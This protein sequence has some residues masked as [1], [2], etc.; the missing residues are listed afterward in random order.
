MA[1]T[2]RTRHSR[3]KREPVTIDLEPEAVR[4]ESEE[5]SA[6]GA[7]QEDKAGPQPAGSEA[8]SDAAET[9]APNSNGAEQ[10]AENAES[11]AAEEQGAAGADASEVETAA[12]SDGD[13]PPDEDK[14][15]QS[16]ER[17]QR[18]GGLGRALAAG[19]IGGAVALGLGAG[20]QRANI[21][22][23]GGDTG[24]ESGVES[25]RQELASIQSELAQMRQAGS[26]AAPAEQLS[27][28][29]SQLAQLRDT[30]SQLQSA[31]SGGAQSGELAQRISQ[32]E[33]SV[34]SAAKAAEAAQQTSAGHTEQLQ[35]I[36]R[37]VTELGNQVESQNEGPRLALIVAASALKSAVE[38][39]SPFASE[40]ETYTAL[41]PDAS[42]V[43]P[44]KPYA[45]TGVP[46]QAELSNEVPQVASQIAALDSQVPADAG[47]LDRLV[48]S[49]RTV[50]DVRP[51]G[52]VE[53]EAPE[54][55][56][57]RMEAAVQKGDY[58]QALTEY[59]ALP[60]QAKDVASAFADKLRARQT[61][62]RIL[63]EAL[64][65]ALKPA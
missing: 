64:S 18:G 30:V 37:Q 45:E 63:K 31:P 48:A 47:L 40:L 33:T 14:P 60:P 28:L 54:A 39:G 20:L 24:S 27:Q 41:A 6:S 55:I 38:S 43:E 10:A 56:A 49:A 46:T 3:T 65:G 36:A 13:G 25:L 9:D 32:V 15:E 52:E 22:P 17:K 19:L 35:D 5:S 34:E 59:E 1:R 21:L 51:V 29:E 50:V 61:A 58:A 53:G 44:L 42:A 26:G 16:V 8:V 4:R 11:T 12:S 62:D 2:P 23:L 7:P 57:A